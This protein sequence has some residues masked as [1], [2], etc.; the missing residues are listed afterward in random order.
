MKAKVE[1]YIPEKYPNQLNDHYSSCKIRL[2]Y[3]NIYVFASTL[4]DNFL[5]LNIKYRPLGKNYYVFL[6]IIK[7]NVL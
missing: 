6:K 5:L 7:A 2:F 3:Y 1:P 4:S